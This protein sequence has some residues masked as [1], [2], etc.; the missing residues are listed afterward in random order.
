MMGCEK[1]F[2]CAMRWKS[3]K[4]SKQ[5]QCV[6]CEN[7]FFLNE[8]CFNLLFFNGMEINCHTLTA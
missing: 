4:R 3:F 7:S 5:F 2:L 6:A 8:N 1:P